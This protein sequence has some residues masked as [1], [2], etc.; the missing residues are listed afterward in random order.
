MSGK[1]N[2]NTGIIR[3]IIGL[4]LMIEGVFM[5]LALPFSIYYGDKTYFTFSFFDGIHEFWPLTI[6]ALITSVTG[7]FLWFY[8]KSEVKKNIGKREG[9]IIVSLAWV[10]F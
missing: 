6:S 9:Y 7:G 8:S 5:I 1:A 4:L 3:R 10:V 2:F